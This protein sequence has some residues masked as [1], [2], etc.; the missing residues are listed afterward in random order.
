M[1]TDHKIINPYGILQSDLPVIV[2]VDNRR[3]FISWAIK[4]HS[5][6]NYNHIMLMHRFNYFASQDIVGFREVKIKKYLY[7][8][9][10]LKFWK[11]KD[12]QPIE[13]TQIIEEITKD[14]GLPWWKRRYDPW[15]II[16][17]IFHI[18]WFNNP[19][20]AYCSEKVRQYLI[21]PPVKMWIPPHPTPSEMNTIFNKNSQME[22]LGYW[23]KED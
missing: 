21:N 9:Y 4:S 14:L 3:A 18:R 11:I 13:R 8:E 12:L 10:I 23:E 6:G 17:Q 19:F 16:G 15:G 5:V 7:P 1:D 2:L 22:L 20:R